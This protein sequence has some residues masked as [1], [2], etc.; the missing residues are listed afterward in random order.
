M[1][2]P[3][4]WQGSPGWRTVWLLTVRSVA[5]LALLAATAGCGGKTSDGSD[6]DGDLAGM[7]L[8]K[9]QRE[10]R[11]LLE[12]M[13]EDGV[14]SQSM[15]PLLRPVFVSFEQRAEKLAR[16]ADKAE[17]DAELPRFEAAY[18]RLWTEYSTITRYDISALHQEV[19]GDLQHDREEYGDVELTPAVRRAFQHLRDNTGEADGVLRDELEAMVAA[20][21]FDAESV[22]AAVRAVKDEAA[23]TQVV[24]QCLRDVKIITEQGELNEE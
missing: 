18:D 23:S 19:E 24:R 2:Q 13:G 22:R 12:I 20:D 21:P 4:S 7:P 3:G 14:T 6:D 8:E 16:T 10:V 17:C 11:D 5:A 9:C 15:R 1:R